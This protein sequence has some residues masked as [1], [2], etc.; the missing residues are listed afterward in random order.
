MPRMHPRTIPLVLL[1]FAAC[2]P[3]DPPLDPTDTGGLTTSTTTGEAPTPTSSAAATTD[4][5]SS[6]GT[7]ASTGMG[8]EPDST[9]GSTSAAQSTSSADST[10]AASTT[11]AGSTSSASTSSA[12]STSTTSAESTSSASTS[13][14]ESAS[15]TS[16]ESTS[17]AST[18]G[19]ASTGE[20]NSEYHLVECDV[21]WD[22]P[23]ACTTPACTQVTRTWSVCDKENIQYQQFGF[24]FG[25]DGSVFTNWTN[26]LTLLTEVVRIAPDAQVEVLLVKNINYPRVEF[27]HTGIDFSVEGVDEG[28]TGVQIYT[29]TG[30]MVHAFGKLFCDDYWLVPGTTGIV[31]T[32]T[33]F[34]NEEDGCEYLSF[35]VFDDQFVSVATWPIETSSPYIKVSATGVYYAGN[36]NTLYRHSLAGPL[37]SALDTYD[38]YYIAVAPLADRQLYANGG[39]IHLIDGQPVAPVFEYWQRRYAPHGEFTVVGQNFGAMTTYLDGAELLWQDTEFEWIVDLDISDLGEVAVWA[40]DAADN[41]WLA[42]YDAEGQRTWKARIHEHDIALYNG[43][44]NGLRFSPSGD[45]LAVRERDAISLFTIQR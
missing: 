34:L 45:Q 8:L 9:S 30:V 21:P 31:R 19:D 35:E 20:D 41:Y 37:L 36:T 25:Q 4:P 14:A 1:L 22:Q 17:T 15:T 42:L 33:H 38:T 5:T 6:S 32:H 24:T 26:D 13:S 27:N 44:Y 7:T 18:S 40:Y 29:D 11:S 10:S 12:E 23:A 16:A 39:L 3:T 2:P 43:R 28:P